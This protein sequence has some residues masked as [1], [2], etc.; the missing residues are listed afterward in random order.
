MNS[1]VKVSEIISETF[2]EYISCHHCQEIVKSTKEDLL[3]HNE[4]CS[5]TNSVEPS[6]N[7]ELIENEASNEKTSFDI[8]FQQSLQ[9]DVENSN[10]DPLQNNSEVLKS[11]DTNQKTS[12]DSVFQKSLQDTNAEDFISDEKENEVSISKPIQN[13]K[14]LQVTPLKQKGMHYLKKDSPRFD[15]VMTVTC[16]SMTAKMY[17]EKFESGGKGKCILFQQEWWTPNRF[18]E[19]AGSK[20]RKYLASIKCLGR[21]LGEFVESGE[22]IPTLLHRERKKSPKKSNDIKSQYDKGVL[23]GFSKEEK[24]NSSSS[25]INWSHMNGRKNDVGQI[26]TKTSNTATIPEND[27]FA[28]DLCPSV[29]KRKES[30][31]THKSLRHPDPDFQIV[32]EIND[33]VLKQQSKSISN[34]H[35]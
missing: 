26:I 33:S 7:F 27:K 23:L 24:N 13:K 17:K 28:C 6:E 35:C 32:K 34:Q 8:I 29:F 3:N 30:L 19:M 20:S 31:M 15:S 21:P 2:D 1:T 11:E 22:L 4:S 9:S 14:M 18:E 25:K 16:K 12:F 10:S 5:R